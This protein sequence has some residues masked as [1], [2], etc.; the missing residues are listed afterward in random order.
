M[1]KI[2]LKFI[3]NLFILFIGSTS[4]FAQ[5]V[6]SGA[7]D[8]SAGTLRSQVASATVGSTI[9]F[10]AS[11][12][13]VTL[14]TGQ[15]TIDK[16]LT[17]TGNGQSTTT[18]NGNANGRIFDVTTGNFNLNNIGLTNG[19]ADN[20]GAI[21]LNGSNLTLSLVFIS[22]CTANGTSG[23][24]GAI[25]VGPNSTLT[26]SLSTL[27]GNIS[28]RAGGAI[29]V[30]AGTTTTLTGVN[31]MNNN[32]GVS[33]ATAAP[34]NGGALH[35]TGAAIVN[36]TGGTIS[37]N[38][39]A[40][41]GGGLWNGAGTMTVNG[42]TISSNT[43]S[44]VAADNGGGGVYNLNNGTLTITNATI[45]SN[46]ANG[47]AGSGGGILSDVGSFLNISNTSVTDN[48]SNRAGGGIELQAGST[49]TLSDVIL[50][51][52]NTGV[53][54]AVAA[55]GNGGGL[56]ITGNGNATIINGTANGNLAANQ[57]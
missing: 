49:A 53:S 8:G 5:V 28:N 31:L 51:G 26:A 42:S 24:G 17:I 37:N 52:N 55:P 1:N 16:S 38:V 15:I 39:A 23:S 48:R 19:L 41:E 44:G 54:P 25:L 18:I 27:S 29:E 47:T 2:T 3:A 43:A 57:G 35:V 50:G 46:I 12:T 14:T 10:D 6:T 4:V 11:V 45:S 7:D 21:Q 13:N 34:G 40:S 9:T 22:N 56:H 32:A 36:I 20:G 30:T 33:P